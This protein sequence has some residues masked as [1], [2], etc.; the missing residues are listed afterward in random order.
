MRP[1][2]RSSIHGATDTAEQE[3]CPRRWPGTTSHHWSGSASH[4]GTSAASIR[5]A[6]LISRS[7]WPSCSTTCCHGGVHRGAVGGTSAATA[8][9]RPPGGGGDLVHRRPQP[10]LPAGQAGPGPRHAAGGQPLGQM[11]ADPGGRAGDQRDPAEPRFRHGLGPGALRGRGQRGVP[12]GGG[13]L[14]GEGAVRRAQGQR[15][16]QRPGARRH[17]RRR[18]RRRRAAATRAAPP[19]PSRRALVDLG[20]R[21]RRRRRRAPGRGAPAGPPRWFGPTGTAAGGERVDVQFH[22]RGARR[23]GP[24]PRTPSGAVRRRGRRPDRRPAAR[25][26]ARGARARAP[27]R[28]RSAP[29]RR[30]PRPGARPR[31]RPP[32]SPGR[33]GPHQPRS[34]RLPARATATCHGWAGTTPSTAA[35]V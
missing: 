7:T 17:G 19:P 16:G 34:S 11:P 31:R 14:A 4:S 27:P 35:S 9:V 5:P 10:V 15:V 20:R 12:D 18:C 32:S 3:R 6:L 25:R 21:G 22:D 26:T 8:R 30:R 23:A 28:G 29:L 2:L 13:L 1:W 33:P 24:A